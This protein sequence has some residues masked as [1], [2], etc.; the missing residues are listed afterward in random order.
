MLTMPTNGAPK[1]S[2]LRT[3]AAACLAVSAMV[4]PIEP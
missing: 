4:M 1:K 3:T 2:K